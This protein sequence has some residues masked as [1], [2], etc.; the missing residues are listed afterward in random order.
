MCSP[1]NRISDTHPL[2]TQASKLST[3]SVSTVLTILILVIFAG[4]QPESPSLTRMPAPGTIPPSFAIAR[5]HSPQKVIF[6]VTRLFP[7]YLF[8]QT[9]SRFCQWVTGRFASSS[10]GALARPADC[11]YGACDTPLAS[12]CSACSA[13]GLGSRLDFWTIFYPAYVCAALRA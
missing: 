12:A 6:G 11:P 5:V 2:A 13:A 1:T 8:F 3:Y 9:P 10:R 7:L 4:A